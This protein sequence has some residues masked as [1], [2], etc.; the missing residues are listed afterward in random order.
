[1]ACDYKRAGN[2]LVLARDAE[3]TQHENTSRGVSP[4]LKQQ[5]RRR[6]RK[7]HLKI[8]I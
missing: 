8:N 2:L 7:L 6:W 3:D 1:M 4:K 5:R